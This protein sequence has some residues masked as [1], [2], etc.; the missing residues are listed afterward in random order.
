MPETRSMTSKMA[1]E[2]ETLTVEI[3]KLKEQIEQS[4]EP[5]LRA[6]IESLKERIETSKEGELLAEIA[7][8]RK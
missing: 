8:L 2:L 4:K 6:E 7:S 1:K 5:E 3:T